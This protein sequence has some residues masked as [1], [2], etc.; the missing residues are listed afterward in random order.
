MARFFRTVTKRFFITTNIVVAAFFLLACAN[1]FLNP[2][3]W[4]FIALLGLAFPFLL[5]LNV[6][7][8]IFWLLFRSKWALVPLLT[9]VVGYTNI[10]ALVGFNFAAPEFNI[11]K[12]DSTIRVL[13]WNV[14]SFDEQTRQIKRPST[15][16]NEMFAFI[17]KHQ[18]DIL[19]FQEY[20]E[21]NH[22]KFYSN[23]NDLVKMGY[24]YYF[25]VSDYERRNGSFQVG[26]AIFSKFPIVDSNRTQYPGP[27]T[28]R[29]A[30]SL[31]STDIIAYGQ[32]IRVFTTHLQSVL[33][34][35]KDFRSL[36]I[37]KNVEDSMM[38]ASKSLVKKLRIGYMF[39]G[40]QV[41]IARQELDNSPY[42][43]IICGDFNDIPNSYT[44][45]TVRGERK[46]VFVEKGT[47]L[48]RTFVYISP[49]LRIDYMMT[50]PA[51]EVLQ[52]K[53][54]VLPYSDHFPLIADLKLNPGSKK[55]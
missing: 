15:Y 12:P 38:E 26:V 3:D 47:G 13:S 14:L 19:C 25:K 53:R 1:A 46:D 43:E 22:K 5:A 36:E 50:D 8:L 6:G 17:K 9:L 7:F 27:R 49:T 24:T 21:P 31:I 4:W 45:F 20:L 44:Y 39:R 16:R 28:F 37:I 51:Y 29:A 10:R 40:D 32:R 2:E 11:E 35:K 52:Y 48:G 42:P 33:L 55:P 18:P 41:E 23:V 54:F 30:E 34:Q